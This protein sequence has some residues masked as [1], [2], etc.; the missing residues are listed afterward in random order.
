MLPAAG[1]QSLGRLLGAP[2]VTAHV[3]LGETIDAEEAAR[4]GIVHDRQDSVVPLWG[5]SGG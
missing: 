3:M 1:T 4:R 2:A 5:G